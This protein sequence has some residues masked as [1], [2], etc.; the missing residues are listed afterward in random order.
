MG[1]LLL[2]VLGLIYFKGFDYVKDNFLGH[3]TKE[4][5]EGEWVF[6]EYGNPG[7]KIETPK[8]LKRMDVSNAIPKEAKAMIKSMNMFAYG[9]MIDDFYITVTTTKF[10]KAIQ[11]DLDKAVEGSL[12]TLEGRGAQNVI[13]KTE[14][15][16][17]QKGISG[18]KAYGTF[19]FVDKASQ[20][21][22]KIYYEMLVFGQEDGLQQII[23]MHREGDK[24]GEQLFER[25]LNSVELQTP[26]QP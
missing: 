6:S 13:V 5:V 15:F 24:Y 1:M 23:L 19:S 25:I 22:Q 3:P 9:S 17:T 12:K 4:L 20:T 14:E 2:F 21:S 10:T 18:K 8:V 11:S 16:D 26:G 7:V